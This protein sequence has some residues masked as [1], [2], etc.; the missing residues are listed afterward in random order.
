MKKI[1]KIIF[2]IVAFL[3]VGILVLGSGSNKE[4]DKN[5]ENAKQE[6]KATIDEDFAEH[7]CQDAKLYGD[8]L[9]VYSLINVWDYNKVFIATGGYDKDGNKVYQLTWNGKNK[10]TDDKASFSCHL[11]GKDQDHVTLHYLSVDG[12]A[13][14]GQ[15]DYQNYNKDGQP[16]E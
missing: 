2:V 6:Q 8:V 5:S 15:L 1:L 4:S 9:K 11:S 13:I 7:Y 16:M 3:M 12:N 14:H 10:L